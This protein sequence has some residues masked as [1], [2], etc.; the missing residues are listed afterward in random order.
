[1]YMKHYSEAEFNLMASILVTMMI[2]FYTH[3]EA[4]IWNVFP[5]QCLYKYVTLVQAETPGDTFVTSS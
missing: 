1:M 4:G 5:C 2:S 3:C